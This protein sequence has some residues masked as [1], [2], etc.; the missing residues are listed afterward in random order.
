MAPIWLTLEVRPHIAKYIYLVGFAITAVASW[1]LRDY[2]H[3]AL[4]HIP[5]LRKCNAPDGTYEN[6]CA[7]KGAVLRISFGNFLFFALHFILLIRVRRTTQARRLIHTGFWPLKFCLWIFLLGICFVMPNSAMSGY[8]QFA[9]VLA[10]IWLLFQIIILLDFIYD[11]NEWL[12][13][14]ANMGFVL[15]IGTFISYC[16]AIAIIGAIYKF[17]APHPSCGLNIFFITFTL[18]LALIFTLIS[19]SPWRLETAG[20]LTSGVVFL[21]CAWICWSALASEPDDARCTY[22]GSRGTTAEKA[23]AFILGIAAVCYSVITTCVESRAMDLEA[24]RVEDSELLPYRP[25]FFHAI[26]GLASAYLCMLYISWNLD[27]LPSLSGDGKF[28]VDL[29]WIAVWVK[30]A[31]QWCCVVLYI[32]TLLAPRILRNRDFTDRPVGTVA[33]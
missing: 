8:G 4:E 29:G 13:K 22:Q 7:G 20:L 30:M 31:S 11:V 17:W 21:Y 14:K 26:F 27:T 2:S 5:Q 32:W 16:G 12:L 23:I 33:K 25:E 9:R 6:S 15:V 19:V 18:V 28:Q 1:L 24:Q 10:G 3:N